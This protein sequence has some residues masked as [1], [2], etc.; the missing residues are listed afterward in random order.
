[1]SVPDT[2]LTK[3]EHIR[4]IIRDDI[5]TGRLCPGTLL[6][7]EEQAAR[8]SATSIPVREALRA[9]QADRLVIIRPHQTAMVATVDL[10]EQEDIYAVRITLE[11]EVMRRAAIFAS[12]DAIA[13]LRKLAQAHE[14]ARRG[15]SARSEAHERF[16]FAIYEAAG[17]P[18][19]QRIAADLWRDSERCRR[20]LRTAPV[21]RHTGD[22]G[23]VALADVL[24]T[25]D[26]D[27]AA[28]AMLRHLETS[29][30]A[31]RVA[32]LQGQA[33]SNKETQR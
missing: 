33:E 17:S 8:F 10:A 28:D 32:F 21:V 13:K 3:S 25:R 16:H 26:P 14:T 12:D 24:A 4:R 18:T 20:V 27:R 31:L 1:M 7:L 29:L 19:L 22:V 9:L 11:S 5:L 23:H 15:A 6:K 30:A 2:P